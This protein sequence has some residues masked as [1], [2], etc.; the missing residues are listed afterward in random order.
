MSSRTTIIVFA[1]AAFD[2]GPENSNTREMFSRFALLALSPALLANGAAA[3]FAGDFEKMPAQTGHVHAGLGEWTLPVGAAIG[4]KVSTAGSPC[5]LE[6]T[7]SVRPGPGPARRAHVSHQLPCLAAGLW[8]WSSF[9]STRLPESA[10]SRHFSSSHPRPSQTLPSQTCNGEA[11][12]T[13]C[14]SA[15][16]PSSCYALNDAA[17]LPPSIFQCDKKGPSASA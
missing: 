12:C 9:I 17:H 4:A 3:V 6:K 16:V 8:P 14:K 13:W 10:K 15:A 7:E 11:D 1:P 5:E 2:F